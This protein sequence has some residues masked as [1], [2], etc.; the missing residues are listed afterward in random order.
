MECASDCLYRLLG[1]NFLIEQSFNG[2]EQYLQ[3]C[4]VHLHENRHKYGHISASVPFC[5][6]EVF[7][8]F[9]QDKN[10]VKALN[11]LRLFLSRFTVSS[12]SRRG[13]SLFV[14]GIRAPEICA[15]STKCRELWIRFRD[16]VTKPMLLNY[17]WLA[18]HNIVT[19]FVDVAERQTSTQIDTMC[20]TF[21][22]DRRKERATSNSG[23][24]LRP[25][26]FSGED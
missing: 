4:L 13:H 12:F 2:T 17:I 18:V 1:A 11:Y 6:R 7:N 21:Q 23:M 10:Y 8:V 3:S 22:T 25:E 5:F 20:M 24:V 16:S 9:L 19:N 14:R 26:K 15:A